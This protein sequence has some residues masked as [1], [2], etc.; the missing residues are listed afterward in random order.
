MAAV[1]QSEHSAAQ[2]QEAAS[3]ISRRWRRKPRAGLILGTGLS[4]LATCIET[5][6]V[7]PYD[8]LPHFPRSTAPGHP[9]RLICGR[10]ERRPV[11]AMQGRCHLYE[12][13]TAAQVSFPVRV[14]RAVGADLLIASN[15]SGGLNPQFAQGELM[16]VA[17]H[18]NLMGRRGATIGVAAEPGRIAPEGISPYDASLIKLALVISRREGFAAHQGVYVAVTG[19]N[20]ETR[21][22]YRFLRRMGGDAVGM[23]TV[24]EV[25]T[26]AQCRM[27][28]LAVSI[29]SNIAAPDAPRRVQSGEVIAAARAAAANLEAI[30]RGVL[31]D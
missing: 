8:D 18:I 21:A 9:G 29:V 17:G 30:V 25:T 15:A 16:V 11:L 13:Y 12:G 10:L 27:R 26:A 1:E 23:S 19:P 14:M 7:M 6:L 4:D 28:V 2:V 5:D 22:E 20:Y 24:P 3:A 31:A